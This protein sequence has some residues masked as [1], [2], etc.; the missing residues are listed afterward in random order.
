MIC[1]IIRFVLRVSILA[2]FSFLLVFLTLILFL[3]LDGIVTIPA[4]CHS[5]PWPFTPLDL[6]V[7][8]DRFNTTWKVHF[9][10]KGIREK[11]TSKNT[12][13]ILYCIENALLLFG[14]RYKKLMK[15]QKEFNKRECIIWEQRHILTINAC[16]FQGLD[17][18]Q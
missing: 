6:L 11:R 10:L 9:S 16:K 17:I 13:C 1:P 14:K 18:K 8:Y 5:W 2:W 7:Y 4:F 3:C 12:L 15:M